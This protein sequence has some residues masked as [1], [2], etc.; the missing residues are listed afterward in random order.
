MKGFTLIEMML[1][2]AILGMLGTG[3]AKMLTTPTKVAQ[4]MQAGQQMRTISSATDLVVNDL[5]EADPTSIPWDTLAPVVPN[6]S[7]ITFNQVTYDLV[8][9]TTVTTTITYSYQ[10]PCS[11]STKGCLMR[12]DGIHQNMLLS[13]LNQ[14]D[15]TNPIFLNEVSSYHMIVMT[16]LY[17]PT[18]QP[19]TKLIRQVSIK[20]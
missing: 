9:S 4:Y 12:D 2:V 7:S 10:F 6:G 13:D 5:K 1:T 19:L 15:D 20:G 11:G 18:G 14:P 3:F 17:Q 16:F 8:K